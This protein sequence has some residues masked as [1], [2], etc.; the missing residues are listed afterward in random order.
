[1]A[2]HTGLLV[3]CKVFGDLSPADWVVIIFV[4]IKSLECQLPIRHIQFLIS[5]KDGEFN[6]ATLAVE[7]FDVVREGTKKR[8]K[9]YKGRTNLIL[10]TLLNN[11]NANG[12]TFSSLL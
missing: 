12:Y 6:S 5:A 2:V 3:H 1:M 9:T 4:L 10:P 7:R 11:S 8:R